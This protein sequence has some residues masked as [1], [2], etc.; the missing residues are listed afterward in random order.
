VVDNIASNTWVA[1]GQWL[2]SGVRHIS[3]ILKQ[4]SN[5]LWEAVIF[6]SFF[7]SVFSNNIS[8]MLKHLFSL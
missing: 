8:L 7:L 4:E 1:K 2:I 5:N 6:L 3:V